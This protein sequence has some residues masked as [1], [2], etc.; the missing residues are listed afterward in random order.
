M[1]RNSF[2]CVLFT[3]LLELLLLE[4]SRLAV[5]NYN[6]V[7]G[8]L[9]ISMGHAVNLAI[10]NVLVK[11][12]QEDTFLNSTFLSNSGG[13][14]GDTGWDNNIVEESSVHSLQCSTAR[15]HLRSMGLG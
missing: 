8:K 10:D 2:W 9:G 3:D 1:R 5:F 13:A 6:L 7:S 14:T 11:W 15:S 4:G 12:V